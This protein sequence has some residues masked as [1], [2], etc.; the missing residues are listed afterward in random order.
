MDR[1]KEWPLQFLMILQYFELSGLG[2]G[3]LDTRDAVSSVDVLQF[4][5]SRIS[6]VWLNINASRRQNLWKWHPS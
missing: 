2:D 3:I 6:F 1:K 5:S 4:D